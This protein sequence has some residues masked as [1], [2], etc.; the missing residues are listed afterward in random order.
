MSERWFEDDG[1]VIHHRVEMVDLDR[2][3]VLK[4]APQQPLSDSWHV[5]TIPLI[6][7]EQWFKEA[8]VKWDDKLACQ[9]VIRKKLLSGDFSKFRVKE[10]RF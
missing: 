3:K 7:L 2:A 5:G 10:G 9:E 1:K 4:E 8:G 6:I